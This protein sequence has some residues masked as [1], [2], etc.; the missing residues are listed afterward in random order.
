M[1]ALD[2]VMNTIVGTSTAIIALATVILALVSWP[3]LTIT[4]KWVMLAV[5]MSLVVDGAL[6]TDGEYGTGSVLGGLVLSG[7]AIGVL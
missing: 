2:T 6:L 5:P 1:G 7:L 3:V 4:T